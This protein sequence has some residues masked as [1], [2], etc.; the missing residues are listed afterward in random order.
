MASDS[1]AQTGGSYSPFPKEIAF[2]WRLLLSMITVQRPHSGLPVRLDGA[3][4]DQTG[5]RQA[6]DIDPRRI[7]ESRSAHQQEAFERIPSGTKYDGA[8][9]RKA[10]NAAQW[11]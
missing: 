4:V 2:F 7:E 10:V 1:V 8:A 5:Q 11:S 6:L 3:N 9:T